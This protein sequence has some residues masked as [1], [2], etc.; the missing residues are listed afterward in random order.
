MPY[1]YVG[2]I[3]I[4]RSRPQK[5][6]AETVTQTYQ[7]QYEWLVACNKALFTFC[8]RPNSLKYQGYMGLLYAMIKVSEA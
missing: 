5:F 7:I 3:V 1:I 4:G 8:R 2:T 6:Q